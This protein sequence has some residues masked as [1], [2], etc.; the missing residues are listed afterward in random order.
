M[1]VKL[2]VIA[3][4]LV[5]LMLSGCGA[6][7]TG[8]EYLS[9]ART[10]IEQKDNRSAVIEIKN[11][12]KLNAADQQ[13]HLLLGQLMLQLDQY[14][15]AAVEFEK[16]KQF[17]APNSMWALGLAETSL[18]QG[19]FEDLLRMEEGE[20]SGLELA[21][22]QSFK[23]TALVD[24]GEYTEAESLI[25]TIEANHK[26]LDD[27]IV[28]KS[29]LLMRT[30]KLKE[31]KTL[32]I[33]LLEKQAS[34]V[35]AYSLLGDIELKQKDVKAAQ[36]FYIE[37]NKIKPNNLPILLQLVSTHVLQKEYILAQDRLT[38]LIKNN[39]DHASVNYWQGKVYLDQGKKTKALPFIDKA[40]MAGNPP[41]QALYLAAALYLEKGE[42]ERADQ[43]INQFFAKEKRY[44]D[45]Y[46]LRANIRLKQNLPKEAEEL[47]K[48]VLGP[49]PENPKA[50]IILAAA[51]AQQDKLDESI[52]ILNKLVVLNPDSKVARIKLASTLLS[53][54]QY[55]ACEKE[56]E[57]ILRIAPKDKQAKALEVMLHTNLKNTDKASALIAELKKSMPESSLPLLLE[58]NLYA[59]EQK[60]E[61]A[62]KAFSK[63]CDL[64]RPKLKAC[65]EYGDF[66][67]KQGEYDVAKKAY[68]RVDEK[69]NGALVVMLK[70]AKIQALLNQMSEVEKQLDIIVDKHPNALRPKILLGQ[71]HLKNGRA[72]K[73]L[74][75]LGG[76]SRDSA[77]SMGYLELKAQALLALSRFSD[78]EPVVIKMLELQPKN[79]MAQMLDAMV[80]NGLGQTAKA[81][82]RLKSLLQTDPKNIGVKVSLAKVLVKEKKVDE[83]ERLLMQLNKDVAESAEILNL[84]SQ[85]ALSRGKTQEAME[86]SSRAFAKQATAP[87]LMTL[88]QRKWVNNKKADAFSDLKN[89]LQNNPT[90]ITVRIVL[91]SLYS[92]E[93]EE[94]K[95][96]NE[97]SKIL[98]QDEKNIVALNNLAWQLKD[99]DPKK[100]LE[101][102]TKLVDS[103]P[104]STAALD[105]LAIVLLKNDS[106]DRASEIIGRA[107]NKSQGNPTYIYH[108]AMIDNKKG[109]WLLAI[110]SLS[111]LLDRDINFPEKKQ[112]QDLLSKLQAGS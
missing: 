76:I 45:A 66:A 40:A 17:G 47:A 37:A 41:I 100:A 25:K 56:I 86:L 23:I 111:S 16:L 50:L 90:D 82:T 108:K 51:L 67:V 87:N 69:F 28:A 65:L 62:I 63:A 33:G 64:E 49:L 2:K 107:L 3:V 10:F 9:N 61:L 19:R 6:E 13:A 22:F 75:T 57:N 83:A 102:A 101:L 44:P 91:A 79:K 34:N 11:A 105:T 18:K 110:K 109:D 1:N 8:A 95:A 81:E 20:L 93:G 73:T 60:N 106:L 27:L 89:W 71:L 38:P 12:L 32:L 54:G 52:N 78:A 36:A 68:D 30:G 42:L 53:A 35:D 112:A 80:M 99:S 96:S 4:T 70:Q 92:Q 14:G 84:K 15:L 98:E 85:I 26:D 43:F 48:R 88:I 46:L 21:K 59:S 77:N 7:L 39:P 58:G 74:V 94:A 24:Q 104:N 29:R 5:V 72:D 97:Y 55:A 31:A 103:A